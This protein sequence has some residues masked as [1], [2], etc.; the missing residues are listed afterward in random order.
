MTS[1]LA[2]AIGRLLVPGVKCLIHPP[3]GSSQIILFTFVEW[4]IIASDFPYITGV[5]LI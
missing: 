4:K 1:S 5:Q 3:A 2:L